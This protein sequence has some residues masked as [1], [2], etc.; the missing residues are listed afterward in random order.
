MSCQIVQMHRIKLV[1]LIC[2][3]IQGSCIAGQSQGGSFTKPESV[4]LSDDESALVLNCPGCSRVPFGPHVV[5][6]A[7]RL[8]R[9]FGL[10]ENTI[11]VIHDYSQNYTHVIVFELN[12]KIQVRILRTFRTSGGRGGISNRIG[13]G[14][15]P[16]GAHVI[17]QKQGKGLKKGQTF[18][19]R[20]YGY[21][22][23]V[24]TPT[25]GPENWEH[26]F[27]LTRIL[28]LKGIEGGLNDNSVR[29]GIFFHGTAEEG[30]LGF[31]ESAGCIR[32]SNDDVVEF[33]DMVQEGTIVLIVSKHLNP[34]RIKKSVLRKVDLG[35][36]S[37]LKKIK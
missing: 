1:L 21:H 31:D 19:A 10:K 25:T 28:R 32:L 13:S 34:K 33:F 22:E 29:R 35:S 12:T 4:I 15:T 18:D 8:A 5:D 7:V 11:A 3:L 6:G 30:L 27:V 36:I 17:F 26:D 16:P 14:G 23:T 2:G 20:K 37:D 24:L 9:E